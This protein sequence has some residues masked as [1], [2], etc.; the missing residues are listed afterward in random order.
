MP[1]PRRSSVAVGRSGRQKPPGVLQRRPAI[2]P[3]VMRKPILSGCQC[4]A[5]ANHAGRNGPSPPATSARKK[6]TASKAAGARRAFMFSLG[7]AVPSVSSVPHSAPAS[8][9]SFACGLI[10]TR[11]CACHPWGARLS[12]EKSS[13]IAR[14]S[15]LQLISALTFRAAALRR[16]LSIPARVAQACRSSPL[17]EGV[18]RIDASASIYPAW[19]D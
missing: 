1:S 12:A 14:P 7:L 8:G 4:R 3:A 15:T 13:P 2:P 5:V 19:A 16:R 18:T 10:I 17:Q 6:L 11:H 9:G